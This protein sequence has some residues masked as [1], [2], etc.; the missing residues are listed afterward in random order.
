MENPTDWKT[1][2][3]KRR[4]RQL[5]N[6]TLL[7]I[8]ELYPD[9]RSAVHLV[10]IMRILRSTPSQIMAS[11]DGK[12]RDPYFLSEEEVLKT[13]ENYKEELDRDALEAIDEEE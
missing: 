13:L 12:P 6:T 11:A 8:L 10:N 1:N 2:A 3:K 4:I 7:Q 9:T 5:V